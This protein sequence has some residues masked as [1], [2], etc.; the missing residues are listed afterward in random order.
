[1]LYWALVNEKG[2]KKRLGFARQHP[3]SLSLLTQLAWELFGS[4]LESYCGWPFLS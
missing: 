3:S 2:Q 1:M 4:S